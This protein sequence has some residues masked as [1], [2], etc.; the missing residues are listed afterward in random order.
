MVIEQDF[1]AKVEKVSTSTVQNNTLYFISFD[2]TDS[3]LFS[4]SQSATFASK[5]RER[6]QF[7]V[8]IHSQV[9]DHKN[10]FR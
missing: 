5:L 9:N 4:A 6:V 2:F 7:G 10:D 8:R 1:T 3:M